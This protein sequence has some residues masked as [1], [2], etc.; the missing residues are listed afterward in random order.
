MS[1]SPH[2]LARG[3]PGSARG[4]AAQPDRL[5][6]TDHLGS[7]PA[8][9]RK[10]RQPPGAAQ[11]ETTR[12]EHRFAAK[13]HQPRRG[14]PGPHMPQC[15]PAPHTPRPDPN[16]LAAWRPKNSADGPALRLPFELPAQS[17]RER[18]QQPNPP[19]ATAAR[20][21]RSARAKS[22]SSVA[23]RAAEVSNTESACRSESSINV[24]AAQGVTSPTSTGI[25]QR[26]RDATAQ[27]S[28]VQ[29]AH[30]APL[31]L[32]IEWVGQPG[33]QPPPVAVHLDKPT[34]LNLLYRDR[35]SQRNQQRYAQRFTNSQ[36][37]QN[38]T[39]RIRELT[40]PSRHQF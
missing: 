5:D 8:P 32:S 29:H 22:P 7:A 1:W 21:T 13:P 24:A 19:A 15:A 23:R 36:N 39:L 4:I 28:S 12:R 31:Y 35:I 18:R 3:C 2:S 33:L 17:D 20:A 26:A 9:K 11:S 27:P 38:I 40:D 25:G 16:W 37:I 10:R 6:P 34:C 14:G 30:L